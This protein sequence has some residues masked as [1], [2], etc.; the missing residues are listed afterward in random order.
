MLK[1][2]FFI[3]IDLGSRKKCIRVFKKLFLCARKQNIIFNMGTSNKTIFT[4]NFETKFN[5]IAVKN[6]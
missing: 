2:F 5:H 6:N 1:H 4:K 3:A